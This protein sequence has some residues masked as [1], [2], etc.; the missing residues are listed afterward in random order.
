E[1]GMKDLEILFSESNSRFL[2]S[3]KKENFA[4]VEKALEGLVFAKVGVTDGSGVLSVKGREGVYR[5]PMEERLSSYQSTL[6]GI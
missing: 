5:I 4:A 3:C 2:F 6:A 1:K